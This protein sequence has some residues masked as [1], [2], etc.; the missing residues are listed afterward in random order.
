MQSLLLII[1][2]LTSI[3]FLAYSHHLQEN[4]TKFLVL[5]ATLLESPNT[6]VGIFCAGADFTFDNAANS[7][8]RLEWRQDGAFQSPCA[9]APDRRRWPPRYYRI[10]LPVELTPWPGV[11]P[12]AI[13]ESRYFR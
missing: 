12:P 2:S 8:L 9:T 4:I 5:R 3:Q 11:L 1:A 7:E 6:A 13:F 10:Q